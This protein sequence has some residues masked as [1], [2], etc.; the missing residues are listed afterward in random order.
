MKEGIFLNYIAVAPITL[1]RRIELLMANEE[2]LLQNTTHS[3]NVNIVKF[4]FNEGKPYLAFTHYETG[5]THY[6]A[7]SEMFNEDYVSYADIRKIKPDDS[8]EQYDI[9]REDDVIVDKAMDERPIDDNREIKERTKPYKTTKASK[10][11]KEIIE[12]I[13]NY[14][15]Y[16]MQEAEWSNHGIAY[17]KGK[18]VAD[19]VDGNLNI[20]VKPFN[21]F[22]GYARTGW[23]KEWF[24]VTFKRSSQGGKTYPYATKNYRTGDSV[25][26]LYIKNDVLKEIGYYDTFINRKH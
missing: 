13:A 24:D 16:L 25:T 15:R 26:A 12:Q 21:K 6:K 18:I 7:P 14:T 10:N 1:Q 9:P 20:T 2:V 19:V 11:R 23:V 4:G 17:I 22:F 3:K 5:I 8:V